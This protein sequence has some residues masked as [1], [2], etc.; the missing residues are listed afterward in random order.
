M[1]QVKGIQDLHFK[2]TGKVHTT[3][4]A[5]L[6][7]IA[8]FQGTMLTTSSESNMRSIRVQSHFL[9]NR[10]SRCPRFTEMLGFAP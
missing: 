2:F 4:D 1:R 6:S 7:A 3:F 8:G 10:R 5:S 9:T